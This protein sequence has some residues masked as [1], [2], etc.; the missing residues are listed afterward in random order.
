MIASLD[1]ETAPFSNDDITLKK[2]DMT[3]SEG[4]VEDLGQGLGLTLPMTCSSGDVTT[5]LYRLTSNEPFPQILRPDSNAKPLDVVIDAIVRASEGSNPVVE[6]R[7][8]TVV[9]FS[10]T[11]NPAF[12]APNQPLQRSKRPAN[13]AVSQSVSPDKDMLGPG[14]AKEDESTP[15]RGRSASMNDMGISMTFTAPEGI[16]V[17]EPFSLDVFVVNR[18]SKSRKLAILVIPKRKRADMRT[19]LSRPSISSSG[20]RKDVS[21]ADAVTDENILYA[22]HRNAAKEGVQII[23]LSNDT[24]VG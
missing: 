8:R 14:Q 22:M 1:V 18:S 2:I 11:L 17:G 24:V 12:G 13:L 3:L 6:M 16:Y 7:W 23:S 5:F 19:H 15:R 20:G 21:V 9:D 4:S 10:A